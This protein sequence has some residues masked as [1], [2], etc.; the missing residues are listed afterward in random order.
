MYWLYARHHAQGRTTWW[1]TS[2]YPN[3]L[4]HK[5]ESRSKVKLNN[6]QIA[7][8]IALQSVHILIQ[9]FD[10]PFQKELELP[11]SK[12]QW[13]HLENQGICLVVPFC[14]SGYN[15]F[16]N[17]NKQV[18]KEIMAHNRKKKKG[19][20]NSNVQGIML[21]TY[22]HINSLNPLN[23]VSVFKNGDNLFLSCN[24]GDW[25][26]GLWLKNVLFFFKH[27][28]WLLLVEICSLRVWILVSKEQKA[29]FSLFREVGKHR[30]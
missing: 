29:N 1:G 5:F 19:G 4:D 3:G 9:F 12:E 18:L 13:K 24:I 26:P 2:Y 27:H 17:G 23:V 25:N 8:W 7:P 20:I 10:L 16:E 15:E 30:H 21:C 11:T 28:C 14:P 6:W 22:M